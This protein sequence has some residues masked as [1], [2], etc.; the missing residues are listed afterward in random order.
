MIDYGKTSPYVLMCL[1][2]YLNG[3]E[4]L[5]IDWDSELGKLLHQIQLSV[6]S[7]LP[8]ILVLNEP[9]YAI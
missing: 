2:V 5:G 7:S 1:D 3:M 6:S 8:D 9:E 4:Y